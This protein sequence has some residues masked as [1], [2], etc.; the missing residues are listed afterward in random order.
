MRDNTIDS[1]LTKA[2]TSTKG[3][4]T[5]VLFEVTGIIVSKIDFSERFNVDN[6]ANAYVDVMKSAKRASRASGGDG[7]VDGMII[8]SNLT[9][10]M[11]EELD[12][13]YMIGMGLTIDGNLGQARLALRNLKPKI[14][15]IL[16]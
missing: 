6:A 8:Y 15:E 3:A 10:V 9:Y 1:L 7:Q 11:M 13:E 16:K 2:I 4:F 12:N 5:A 14:R